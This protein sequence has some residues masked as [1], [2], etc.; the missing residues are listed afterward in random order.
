MLNA[1]ING[2]AGG[3]IITQ[4]ITYPLQTVNARQQTDRDPK[5]ARRK[6][7]TIEQMCQTHTKVSKKSWPSL[8]LLVAPDEA[9]LAAVDPPPYRTNHAFKEAV[10]LTAFFILETINYWTVKSSWSETA[11]LDELN[12]S[13]PMIF[14]PGTF[15]VYRFKKY[16][17]KLEF[18]VSNPSIQFM[19]YETLL[20]KL[21][22]RR[23][24]SKKINNGVTA[25]EI[26]L[27]GAVAKLGA[28]VVTYP[29][30]VVKNEKKTSCFSIIWL[31]FIS[32]DLILVG[33]WRTIMTNEKTNETQ[34]IDK[35][36]KAGPNSTEPFS[37]D[38]SENPKA[39]K[40]MKKH[41]GARGSEDDEKFLK[42]LRTSELERNKML[43]NLLPREEQGN[44]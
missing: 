38:A 1:L 17:V 26:F 44:S 8:S 42:D 31:H 9:I 21:K 28:T 39:K 4:L 25:L 3:V 33:S 15:T 20:K 32:E 36:R 11:E 5:K 29:L 2:L 22:A 23:D 27:L 10:I 12:V 6:L 41:W 19:L 34:K 14:E 43:G 40:K 30:L 24:S 18:G 35:G 16:M 13:V 7:G 37:P